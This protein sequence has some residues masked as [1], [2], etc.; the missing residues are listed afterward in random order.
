MKC[1][2][3]RLNV[4]RE[5]INI[6]KWQIMSLIAHDKFLGYATEHRY[7]GIILV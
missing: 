7:V 2:K 6:L 5:V 4:Q 1:R 3:T